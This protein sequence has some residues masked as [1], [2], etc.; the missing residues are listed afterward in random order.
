ML[1]IIY[2]VYLESID[3]PLYVGMTMNFNKRVKD[4][5]KSFSE[6]FEEKVSVIILEAIDFNE[7][8]SWRPCERKWIKWFRSISG[9]NDALFN[10]SP[11][12][13]AFSKEAQLKAAKIGGRNGGLKRK[14]KSL[15]DSWKAK[16][17]AATKGKTR[18]QFSTSWRQNISA[19]LKGKSRS[20]EANIKMSKT[21]H[22]NGIIRLKLWVSGRN[23]AI[24]RKRQLHHLSLDLTLDLLIE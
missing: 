6:I 12:G 23:A 9:S 17:S 5:E 19:G 15:T 18:E 3:L 16:M 13:N 22:E 24:I 10:T 4:H 14:G 20:E 1:T 11:G 2:L 7:S 8:G 21:F